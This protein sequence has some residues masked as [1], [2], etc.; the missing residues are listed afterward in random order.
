VIIKVE[1]DGRSWSYDDDDLTVL[2]GIAIEDHIKGTL[3]DYAQG[4]RSHRSACFQA[5]GWL[6][7]HGGALDGK[8]R[9]DPP[10]AS[11]DFPVT[12][13]SSAWLEA[14]QA[15]AAELKAAVA[16]AEAEAASAA[17]PEGGLPADTS[18]AIPAGPEPGAGEPPG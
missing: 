4:L 3:V 5:L 7:F 10:I 6:V 16:E 1:H 8:G 15:L 12:K 13:L 17:P 11:V 9:A 18:A 14:L 2:Q